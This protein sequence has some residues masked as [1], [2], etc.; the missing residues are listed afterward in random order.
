MISTLKH[1]ESDSKRKFVQ[2]WFGSAPIGTPLVGAFPVRSTTYAEI[3]RGPTSV[4][5]HI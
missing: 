5:V 3:N 4:L 1:Y 2:G